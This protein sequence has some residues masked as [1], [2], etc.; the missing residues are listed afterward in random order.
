MSA[1]IN[2]HSTGLNVA[3]GKLS[4]R[5]RL[6]AAIAAT[7]IVV[8]VSALTVLRAHWMRSPA[9]VELTEAA[10]S[11]ATLGV[12]STR[13]ERRLGYLTVLGSVSN[14]SSGN[15]RNVEAVA[16]FYDASKRLVG[17]ESA[18]IEMPVLRPGRESAF[19]ITTRDMNDAA[20]FRLRFRSLFGSALTSSRLDR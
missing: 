10:D 6:Y 20:A 17:L 13:A 19:R 3:L 14:R 11:S 16:E 2:S 18:L 8:T 5:L 1:L 12:V 7:L 9:P 15:L 4:S